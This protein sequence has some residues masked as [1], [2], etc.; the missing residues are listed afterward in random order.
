[1]ECN[2]VTK[3]QVPQAGHVF[4]VVEEN[5]SYSSVIGN[6]SMPYLNAVM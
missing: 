6:T 5:R 4:V 2:P 3:V 1:M